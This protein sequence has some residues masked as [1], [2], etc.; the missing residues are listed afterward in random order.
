[1]GNAIMKLKKCVSTGLL[2]SALLVSNTEFVAAQ[3]SNDLKSNSQPE[4]SCP[5]Q[6]K[7][8]IVVIRPAF[9]GQTS[10]Y[11]PLT[12]LPPNKGS[13]VI[14][15][16]EGLFYILTVSHVYEKTP[17]DDNKYIVMHPN[18]VN[19]VLEVTKD[20]A[21]NPSPKNNE[22][23]SDYRDITILS[24]PKLSSL[25]KALP[26]TD[27]PQLKPKSDNIYVAGWPTNKKELLCLRLGYGGVGKDPAGQLIKYLL[28]KDNGTKNGHS[29]G[30][31]AYKDK[32]G[33]ISLIG[34]HRSREGAIPIESFLKVLNDKIPTPQPLEQQLD[35][36]K[37]KNVEQPPEQTKKPNTNG[38]SKNPRYVPGRW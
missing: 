5:N 28:D 18:T 6:V 19:K 16:K 30:A 36:D 3:S 23:M 38:S 22:K 15:A 8:S 24:T 29:G 34:I 33:N 14:V 31:V 12:N 20:I 11:P 25:F 32:D 10:P 13:G 4:T 9:G 26:F 2:A 17:I 35:T 1:M 37:P 21:N 27:P 7:D